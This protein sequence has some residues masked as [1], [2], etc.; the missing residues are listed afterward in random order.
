MGLAVAADDAGAVDRQHQMVL[1]ERRVVNKLVIGAL[2]KGGIDRENR[3]VALGSQSAAKGDGVLLGDADVKKAVF[4]LLGKLR[5]A[6]AAC[7]GGSDGADLVVLFRQLTEHLAEFGRKA[8]VAGHRLTGINVELSDPVELAG[9][10]LRR[11]VALAFFGDDMHQRRRGALFCRFERVLDLFHI[12]TVDGSQIGEAEAVKQRVFID[13]IFDLRFAAPQD[14]FHQSA[15]QRDLGEHALGVFLDAYVP[16]LDAHRGEI[17]RN[18]TDVFGDGHFVVVENDN[19]IPV[20][21]SGI[22]ERLK[23]QSAGE[24]AVTDDRDGVAVVTLHRLGVGDAE[25]RR[26]G[27]AAVTGVEVV[28]G[29]FFLFGEAGHAAL[30]TQRIK[31][32]KSAGEQLV[33]VALVADVPNHTVLWKIKDAVH[34]DRQ[35]H[36]TQIRRQMTAVDCHDLDQLFSDLSTE[37]VNVTV[38]NAFDVVR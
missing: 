38:C 21:A 32:V 17:A 8:L 22:V 9:L 10:V 20:E 19:K 6:G 26:N 37:R 12:V 2:Q 27:G 14:R 18:G 23:R 16:R 11:T 30:G 4:V 31:A 5:Q 15:E 35:L 3:T 25:R 34:G 7:H 24:R 33:G 29:A 13:D 1:T 36:H 28:I